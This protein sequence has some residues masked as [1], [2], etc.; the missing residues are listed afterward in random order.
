MIGP[1][2]TLSEDDRRLLRTIGRMPLVSAENLV[3]TLNRK[4]RG[5]EAELGRLQGG[6]WV[7]SIRVGMTEAPQTRWF[8]TRQSVDELYLNDHIHPGPRA[9]AGAGGLEPLRR[10]ASGP[11][12]WRALVALD[13][14]HVPHLEDAALS[15]FVDNGE[16]T[17]EHPPWTA[18]SRGIQTCTRR[19]ALLEAVYRLAPT[20]FLS[21]R[22]L[23]PEDCRGSSP[24]AMTD[25]R[26]LRQGGFYS[27]F[28]RYGVEIWVSFVYAGLHSTERSLRRKHEHRLWNVNGYSSAEDKVFR[29][30]NRLFHEPPSA[31]VQPSAVVVLGA[32]GWAG[33]LARETLP[34]DLP[35]L[36]SSPEGEDGPVT[37]RRSR[38]H[39]ADPPAHFYLGHP[40]QTA[41][42]LRRNRDLT[43]ILD[44]EGYRLFLVIAEFPGMA[45]DSLSDIVGCAAHDLAPVL[46]GF[47]ETGLVVVFDGR[48]YLAERGMRR[49]AN[50]TR[51][52]PAVIRSRHGAYLNRRFRE[53]DRMHNDGVNRIARQLALE[54]ARPVA[55]W[56]AEINLPDVTQVRA[57]L[58]FLVREG[59][60]G[61]GPYRI[62]YERGGYSAGVV[63]RKL[64]P[65]RRMAA[66][67]KP[68][69]LLVVCED[70]DQAR[71]FEA[72]QD[73]LPMLVATE[74]EA[75]AGPMTG[76]S[77]V[78][79]SAIVCE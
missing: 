42:W 52:L 1:S 70:E 41:G 62:E 74:S 69:P 47:V 23:M 22:L 35:L 28:A 67:G 77:T 65:Y 53:V 38:D 57:D 76:K 6:G 9:V 54:G 21:G 31:D 50:L 7:D 56:R 49:A 30:S 79:S 39:I 72:D 58:L 36:V 15:P 25:F 48:C 51:I 73:N 75:L 5:I 71:R 64:G 11:A 29:T 34:D 46:D 44:P 2:S 37:A 24:P 8:L 59:P 12:D 17:H 68:L 45:I 19:L 78:W 3:P 27:A 55:G 43:A 16:A 26:L 33:E 20:L 66:Q 32:D 13:H 4:R 40:E 63:R 61:G 14:E 60:F 18:T 10:S